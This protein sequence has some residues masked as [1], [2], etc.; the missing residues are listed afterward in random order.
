M[1]DVRQLFERHEYLAKASMAFCYAITVSVAMNFFWTPGHIYSSGY[2]GISQLID[3]MSSRYLP[4]TIPTAIGLFLLNIPTFILAWKQIGHQFTVFTVIAVFL[5]S[6]MIKTLQPVYL[7]KDPII[8]A[9]FGGVVNG[10]GTGLSLKN[11]ISTGGLDILG[12]V[13]RRKTGRTIG[14]VNILFNVFI[15][16]A[17][18]LAYGWPYA[19]YSAIGLVVNAKVIDLTYTRQQL[20]QV[21][22]VTERPKSV[23]DSVQNHLRRGITIIHGAEGAYNHAKKTVL[24]TVVSRYEMGEFEE[25][26]NESDP[27]AFTTISPIT[28]IIGRFW[29]P[30]VK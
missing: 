11:G 28:K 25:A 14:N 9:I 1:D 6:F 23:T 8:C 22:I 15:V 5:A 19:F 13:I 26:M 29:E 3:T 7:T 2:T 18:G 12:I 20:L 10:F 27:D 4:F 17:A 16:I 24:F 30:K 21:M